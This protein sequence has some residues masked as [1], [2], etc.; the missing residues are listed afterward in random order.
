MM[1]RPA[2]RGE[3]DKTSDVPIYERTL[4]DILPCCWCFA[5]FAWECR[6]MQRAVVP[7]V[8]IQ[9][10]LAHLPLDCRLMA[11]NRLFD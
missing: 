4:G 2:M 3:Q 10:Q 1:E 6:D 8:F 5:G 9:W 11:P 7:A